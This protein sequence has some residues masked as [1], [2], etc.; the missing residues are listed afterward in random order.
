MKIKKKSYF[1]FIELSTFADMDLAF[2]LGCSGKP[3]TESTDNQSKFPGQL[4][5]PLYDC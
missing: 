1:I 5:L 2:L 4:G 3:D